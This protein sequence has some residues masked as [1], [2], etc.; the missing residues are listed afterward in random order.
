MSTSI[1]RQGPGE[2]YT[3]M[4]S[5][6]DN[7]DFLNDSLTQCFTV[8]L[9]EQ[10]TIQTQTSL[11]TSSNGSTDNSSLNT[12]FNSTKG[13]LETS[14]SSNRTAFSDNKEKP[15][16][17]SSAN[18]VLPF[19]DV[20][21]SVTSGTSSCKQTHSKNRGRSR[22]KCRSRHSS[23]VVN[24][25]KMASYSKKRSA[26]TP[27]EASSTTKPSGVSPSNADQN[28]W[29]TH[30]QRIIVAIHPFILWMWFSCLFDGAGRLWSFLISLVSC[31][32]S[33]SIS[34]FL[35][36]FFYLSLHFYWF[37]NICF[38]VHCDYI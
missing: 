26:A 8:A 37:S 1:E 31:S 27:G 10:K 7:I 34:L 21:L 3:R 38:W 18:Y 9:S 19:T 30:R 11:L 35:S 22:H 25:Q 20:S 4:N 5:D 6:S 13:L 23:N 33:F 28:N 32:F 24:P 17:K 29:F 15:S 36:L 12:S 16:S 2:S 14:C